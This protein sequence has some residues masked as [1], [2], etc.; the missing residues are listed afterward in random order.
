MSEGPPLAKRRRVGNT[1]QKPRRSVTDQSQARILQLSDDVLMLIIKNLSTMELLTLA[2]TCLR[3]K[4]LCL[5]TTSLWLDPDFSGHPMELK[6]MKECL[7]LFHKRTRSLTLEGMLRTKG[8][9]MNLS[10]P[11]LGEISKVCPDLRTLRLKHFYVNAGKIL[12]EHLPSTLT[13]LSLLGSEFHNLPQ[14]YFKN[15]HTKLPILEELDLTNCGWVT[16][17]FLMAICK[18]ETLKVLSLKGCHNVGVCFAYCALATRFG[19][20]RIEKFDLRDTDIKDTE[21]V[22]FGRKPSLKEL[23][24]NHITERGIAN[25]TAEGGSNIERLTLSHCSLSDSLLMTL[26]SEM[27]SLTYLDIRGSDN[28][29]TDGLKL[30]ESKMESRPGARQFCE[31]FY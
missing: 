22:C 7:N 21:L 15:I 13:D 19:F 12:F 28:I 2:D 4:S 23:L 5:E 1:R 31:I 16:D 14:P 30:F 11:F 29:T 18:I 26:A 10:E 3:F 27:K 17:Y 25:V 8:Q 6:R 9:V 24:I 20:N